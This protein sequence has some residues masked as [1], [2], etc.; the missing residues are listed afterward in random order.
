MAARDTASLES[1]RSK[2]V[3]E[4]LQSYREDLAEWFSG[5]PRLASMCL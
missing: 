2:L 3:D 4:R 5:A 1:F